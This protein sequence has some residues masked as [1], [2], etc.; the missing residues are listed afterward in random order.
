MSNPTDKPEELVD[1]SQY[2]RTYAKDMAAA[3]KSQGLSDATT[4]TPQPAP[5]PVPPTDTTDGVS[6]PQVDESLI[7]H[8]SSE[9]EVQRDL[10]CL[11]VKFKIFVGFLD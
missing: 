5:K 6:L 11:N 7:T 1:S 2:M 9:F 10:L 8:T 3:S 4:P